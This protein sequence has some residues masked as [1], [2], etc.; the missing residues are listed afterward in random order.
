MWEAVSSLASHVG[1]PRLHRLHAMHTGC[2]VGL[3]SQA[4]VAYSPGGYKALGGCEVMHNTLCEAHNA[5]SSPVLLIASP[6]H[7]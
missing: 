7:Y 6:V 4:A 1:R 3:A 5:V 2:L